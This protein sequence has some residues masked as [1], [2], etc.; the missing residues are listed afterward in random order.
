M[1]DTNIKYPD[2]TVKIVGQ[3]GNA[4]NILGI[5]AREMRKARLSQEDIDTFYSAAT[6]GDYNNLLNTVMSWFNVE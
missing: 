2:I 5:C 1:T 3:D 6:A 4:F